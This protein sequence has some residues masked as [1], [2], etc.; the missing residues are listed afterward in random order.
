MESKAR[1]E[2]KPR[3]LA[4]LSG[5]VDSAAA[6]AILVEQGYQ[7]TG[8]TM[9][10]WSGRPSDG[11]SLHHGCYGPEEESDI[12]D[13]RR[14]AALLDIPYH[15]ID[16]T[17]EYRSV[18]LD[19]FSSEYLSGRT[20]NPCV[21]CNHRVKFGA[22]IEKA[23]ESGLEF[24]YTASGHYARV[25][26]SGDRCLLK[27]ARDLSKDQTYFLVFL[28]QEQ[29][30]RVIFPLGGLTKAEVRIIASRTGLPVA[31]KPDSQ[32]FICGDYSSVIQTESKPG[33]II[34]RQGNILGQHR[35]IQ[36]YTL[37]QRRG[38]EIAAKKPLYVIGLDP[39]WN[40]VI[41]GGR[42]E[43]YQDEFTA[44]NLNWTAIPAP[45]HPITADVKI[46]SSH[47]EAEAQIIPLNKEKVRVKFVEPQMAITPGQ[48]A[49]FYRED[50]VLGG[51]IIEEVLK[52]SVP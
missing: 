48:T 25:E 30:S 3:V 24:D 40:T 41:V 52:P 44:V 50:V 47:K 38:L 42:A 15:V 11:K 5:G 35:G 6:A 46:R 31:D 29:L 2:T 28:S 10:I 33:P 39:A 27:K 23:R 32:N 14:V 51:G 19:Y 43:I 8:V 7:V 1:V 37:G 21:R 16:L 9:R 18:V 20:P 22:L 4:L 13:A 26:F 12:E 17:R 49:V 36:H 45:D 34:D